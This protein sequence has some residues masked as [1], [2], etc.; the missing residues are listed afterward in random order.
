MGI[1]EAKE[2]I[3]ILTMKINESRKRFVELARERQN[4]QEYVFQEQVKALQAEI[5][6]LR[7]KGAA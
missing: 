7:D 5:Q 4:L 6:A 3:E 1:D 2:R